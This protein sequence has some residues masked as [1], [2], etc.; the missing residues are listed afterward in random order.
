MLPNRFSISPFSYLS[1]QQE[2]HY[3]ALKWDLERLFSFLEMKEGEFAVVKLR[4]DIKS[5]VRHSLLSC[6]VIS[7]IFLSSLSCLQAVILPNE[8]SFELFGYDILLDSK[9]KPWLMEV[10]GSPSLEASDEKDF[11]LKENIICDLIDILFPPVDGEVKRGDFE[12]L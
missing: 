4:E 9:L 3:Q 11:W 7:V 5:L 1:S 2:K 12:L 10:N 6:E 8:H